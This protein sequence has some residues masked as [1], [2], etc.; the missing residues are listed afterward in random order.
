MFTL[1]NFCL[2]LLLRILFCLF[3]LLFVVA[4]VRQAFYVG[5]HFLRPNFV[6]SCADWHNPIA[7]LAV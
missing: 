7:A 3:F 1:I 2:C 6:A 5:S 4:V